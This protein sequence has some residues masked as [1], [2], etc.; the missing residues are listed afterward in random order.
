MK[1]N[2]HLLHS[3]D[4]TSSLLVFHL[5]LVYSSRYEYLCH[6]YH[7]TV[8]VTHCHLYDILH[9]TAVEKEHI[10]YEKKYIKE[11]CGIL[12]I[13]WLLNCITYMYMCMYILPLS[14]GSSPR[15]YTSPVD[16]YTLL[17]EKMKRHC[18]QHYAIWVM[19][20]VLQ[21]V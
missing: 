20:K 3:H 10:K 2:S 17:I 16:S 11:K 5:A 8:T 15:L 13:L 19:L 1:I 9:R 14:W 4:N 12:T 6:I 7:T 18:S 21:Q